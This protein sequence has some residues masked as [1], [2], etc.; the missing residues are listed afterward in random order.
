MGLRKKN[1]RITNITHMNKW[2]ANYVNRKFQ[3]ILSIK[4]NSIHFLDR[5]WIIYKLLMHNLNQIKFTII[6]PNIPDI[7]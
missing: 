2:T 4:E 1:K 7:L 3:Q 5:I 6:K